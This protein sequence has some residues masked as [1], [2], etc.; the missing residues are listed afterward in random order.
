MEFNFK[1]KKVLVTG[2]TRGI[3]AEIALGFYKAGALVTVTATSQKSANAF[4]KE[5]GMMDV[6]LIEVDFSDLE[7]TQAVARKLSLESYDILI[8]N[9]GINKVDPLE[10]IQLED[11]Q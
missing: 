1:G 6:R 11:W 8:N 2:G 7:A 10:D 5:N 4:F 9:A 3:G